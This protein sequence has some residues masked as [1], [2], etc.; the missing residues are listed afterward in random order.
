MPLVPNV[1]Q[2]SFSGKNADYAEDNEED[3]RTENEV[4][5]AED[6]D[7]DEVEEEEPEA[8]R[9]THRSQPQQP[10]TSIPT[11]KPQLPT[12]MSK[13][14]QSVPQP[15]TSMSQLPTSMP[16]LTTIPQPPTSMSQPPVSMPQPISFVH[17]SP[18]SMPQPP[19]SN[20]HLSTAKPQS[21]PALSQKVVTL[22]KPDSMQGAASVQSLDIFASVKT[23]P[24]QLTCAQ[25][26]AEIKAGTRSSPDSSGSASSSTHQNTAQ[27]KRSRSFLK[28]EPGG[29][30]SPDE[31]IPVS[32][33]GG[34]NQTPVNGPVIS[35][36][37]AADIAELR[38][39][40]MTC[41]SLNRDQNKEALS[42][43]LTLATKLDKAIHQVN[44]LAKQIEEVKSTHTQVQMEL[45][46]VVCASLRPVMENSLRN[47]MR[48]VVLPELVKSMEP[49]R[50]RMSQEVSGLLKTTENQ[51]ID[52]ISKMVHSRAF[53]DNVVSAMSSVMATTV[54]NSC[55][56][57][58]SKLLLPG[59]N[60][61]TQQVFVQINESF[62]RGT[63]EYLQNVE[64]EVQGG[65]T[66]M[67]DTLAKASQSLNSASSSITAQS[68]S[69]QDNVSK[70]T[71]QQNT[72]SESLSD[73]I[74]PLVREEITRALQ[75]HQSAI[76]ARSRTHTPA[77]TQHALNPKV[78]QQQLQTLISQGQ[79]NT[80]FKQA[81][82]ASD[83]GLVVFV[84][85][86]VNPQQVFN[87]TPCPLSQ[88]VLLSL[89]NQLSHDLSTFTDLKMKYLEEAVMNFDA[90][91]PVTREHM[92]TV[93][94]GFQCNLTTYLSTNPNHKK[95]KM[96]L[97]AVNHLVALNQ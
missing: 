6:E 12:P 85:E 71:A 48:N 87:M 15:P 94:Q 28:R 82:S 93:L 16:P 72:L 32:S 26:E 40:M 9:Q 37:S 91:H 4:V 31:R 18:T 65:R 34:E 30:S 50:S 27:V 89:V 81:L 10:P 92:R 8:L 1:I 19:N 88:D 35:G 13:P 46:R 24:A 63:R 14:L 62:S 52:D 41:I 39:L 54:Q 68:K 7:D 20:P 47:E 29:R 22:Q 45:P 95:V 55:R 97:M 96:L 53:V 67:H 77:P 76:D 43:T 75:E 74:R 80:A 58:Y 59:L 60:T 3:I 38:N 79:F 42:Q 44:Q 49:L 78:A 25:L 5:M 69:L 2:F 11:P 57:A 73:R 61:L 56:E 36:V 33:G 17:M 90:S 66:A 84:C 21:I 64:S 23:L 86:R 51:V 70:L 83:L